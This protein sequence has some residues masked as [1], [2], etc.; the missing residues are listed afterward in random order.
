MTGVV[1]L[2]AEVLAL[3]DAPLDFNQ[4][5]RIKSLQHVITESRSAN[6]GPV[7]EVIANLM[8]SSS[9]IPCISPK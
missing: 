4:L 8:E 7:L 9:P 3:G 5:P 2:R 6:F 1:D